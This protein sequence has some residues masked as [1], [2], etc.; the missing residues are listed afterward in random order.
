MDVYCLSREFVVNI[1]QFLTVPTTETLNQTDFGVN[2]SF[3]E[4]LLATRLR[5]V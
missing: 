3:G 2:L 5:K 4:R 1:F